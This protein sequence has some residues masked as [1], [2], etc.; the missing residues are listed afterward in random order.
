MC[1]VW[2]L[3]TSNNLDGSGIEK[4]VGKLMLYIFTLNLHLFVTEHLANTNILFKT[5]ED[6]NC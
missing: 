2:I 3:K 6:E 4:P 5:I 1:I